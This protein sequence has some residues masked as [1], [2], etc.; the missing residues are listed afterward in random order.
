MHS[1]H[2]TDKTHELTDTLVGRIEIKSMESEVTFTRFLP[3]IL[4]F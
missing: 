1:L 3:V 4:F 2:N